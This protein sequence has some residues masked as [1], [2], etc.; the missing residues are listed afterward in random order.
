MYCQ[1]CG[2]KLADNVKFCPMCGIKVIRISEENLLTDNSK[3]PV[4]TTPFVNITN[5]GKYFKLVIIAL[6]LLEIPA[7]LLAILILNEDE[8]ISQFVSLSYM[9]LWIMLIVLY[10]VSAVLFCS[11]FH[12]ISKNKI[13]LAGLGE[14]PLHNNKKTL[15]LTSPWWCVGCFFV[16]IVSLYKPYVAMK[17]AWFVSNKVAYNSPLIKWDFIK[18]WWGALLFSGFISNYSMHVSL[19]WGENAGLIGLDIICLFINIILTFITIRLVDTLT[20]A[21]NKAMN[22][23]QVNDNA[24]FLQV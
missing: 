16:P 17:E 23:R 4:K 7:T 18:N 13:V 15:K 5:V 6:L 22:E 21:Q 10:I 8:P 1:N 20:N 11:W 2:V 14:I 3:R 19:R 9:L 24:Y 12:R